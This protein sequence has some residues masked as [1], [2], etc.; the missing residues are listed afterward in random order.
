MSNKTSFTATKT[1]EPWLAINDDRREFCLLQ[2]GAVY[3]YDNLEAVELVEEK[4]ST[5]GKGALAWAYSLN[6]LDESY[7]CRA[8]RVCLIL[9]NCQKQQESISFVITPT[10]N[11]SP[12]YRKLSGSAKE[13]C[14]VLQ[15]K[16]PS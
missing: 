9:K 1:F 5:I 11:N 16:L 10:K 4:A 3:S 6:L 12:M 2:N 8:L 15:T 14:E 13:I 7:I